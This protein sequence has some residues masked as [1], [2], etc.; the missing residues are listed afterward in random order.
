MAFAALGP[1][2]LDSCVRKALLGRGGGGRPQRSQAVLCGL[3]P[4]RILQDRELWE[5]R[6]WGHTPVSRKCPLVSL[7]ISG[8]VM[9]TRL[10]QVGT[11]TPHSLDSMCQPEQSRAWLDSSGVQICT[12]TGK[13]HLCAAGLWGRAGLWALLADFGQA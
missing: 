3:A 7:E 8:A 11:G 10:A 5:H 2:L 6:A 9:V 13:A 4:V 12:S 1:T